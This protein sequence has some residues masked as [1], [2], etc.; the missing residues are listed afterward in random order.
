[1][2]IINTY[3]CNIEALNYIKKILTDLNREIDNNTVIVG[4]SIVYFQNDKSSRQKFN[5]EMLD[6]NSILDHTDLTS[7]NRTFHTTAAEHILLKHTWNILRT[8]HMTGHKKFSKF[9]NTEIIP[10]A[11]SD[12][13]SVTL[14]ISNRRKDEKSQICDN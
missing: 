1:M 8:E 10:N 11:F 7:T 13:S 3:P 14:N 6:L 9:K 12:H 4:T 5:K 2:T